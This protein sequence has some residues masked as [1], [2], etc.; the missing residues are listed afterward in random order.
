MLHDFE[1][2]KRDRGGG[3][4]VVTALPADAARMALDPVM[5][6]G[7]EWRA[8]AAVWRAEASRTDNE[9]RKTLCTQK[10]TWTDEQRHAHA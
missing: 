9:Q 4:V 1:D 10:G 2:R 5:P 6:A 8:K 3:L 7:R